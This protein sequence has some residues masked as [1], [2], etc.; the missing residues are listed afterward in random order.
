[1]RRA[2]D[3]A[4]VV[5]ATVMVEWPEWLLQK[6]VVVTELARRTA[7]TDSTGRYRLCGAP[8]GSRLRAVSWIG[9]DSTGS[10]EVETPAAGYSL[11][12]FVIGIS[13]AADSSAGAAGALMARN[14]RRD[15]AQSEV[16]P[17]DTTTYDAPPYR[18]G[19]AIVR[20]SVTNTDGRPL[21][22]AIVR[23]LGSGTPV[24]AAPDGSFV[25]GDAAA[26][27]YSVEARAIG[28]SPHRVPVVLRTGAPSQVTLQLAGANVQLDTVRVVAGRNIPYQVEAI[29]RRWRTGMGKVLNEVAIRE[30]ATTFVTDALRGLPGVFV[31]Q[32]G[33]WGQAVRMRSNGG[34]ECTAV[35]YVDGMFTPTGGGGGITLDDFVPISN[36]AAIEVYPRATLVPAEFMNLTG[37]GAVAVWT[38]FA[39]ENVRIMPPKSERK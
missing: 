6:R 15:S 37:C 17:V 9:A 5:G 14:T 11:Q 16:T 7:R 27:T 20:G 3:D 26:G 31:Q 19:R 34:G 25:I 30:R 12:D 21:P 2:E 29:E 35:L 24:R 28:Y 22:A 13:T 8:A 23:V 4:P 36:V 32:V 1:V 33:G 39:T 38:K 18:R 10:I